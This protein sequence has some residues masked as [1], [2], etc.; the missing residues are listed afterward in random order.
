[1][2]L[3]ISM[4]WILLEKNRSVD[5]LA[6]HPTHTHRTQTAN[7]QNGFSTHT[8]THAQSLLFYRIYGNE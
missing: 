2:T 3:D 8:H 6:D 1:M 5:L 4:R 7:V